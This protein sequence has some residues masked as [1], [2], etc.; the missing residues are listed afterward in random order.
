MIDCREDSRP[1]RFGKMHDF[2]LLVN[3]GVIIYGCRFCG[4]KHK[5]KT[6]WPET[7]R[8]EEFS[9]DVP[10]EFESSNFVVL[11]TAGLN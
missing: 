6:P 10:L 9:V 7:K 1:C 11:Y 5:T 4:L 8:I 2:K 3:K